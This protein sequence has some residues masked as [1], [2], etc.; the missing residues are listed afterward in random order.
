[1]LAAAAWALFLV[2]R[3][4]RLLGIG[5]ASVLAALFVHSLLYAGFFEDPLTWG[6][7]G[8]A[9]AVLAS[10]PVERKGEVTAPEPAPNAPHLLAH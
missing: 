9:S 7:L 8:L 1:M 10:A 2:T 3:R 4:D 6:V 5:L